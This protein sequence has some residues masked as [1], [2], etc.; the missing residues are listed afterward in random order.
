MLALGEPLGKFNASKNKSVKKDVVLEAWY[1]KKN[2]L[3]GSVAKDQKPVKASQVLNKFQADVLPGIIS[4]EPE[5]LAK[6]LVFLPQ[7]VEAILGG[8]KVLEL[9][10]TSLISNSEGEILYMAVANEIVGRAF[11]AKPIVIETAEQFEKM[12]SFHCWEGV[13]P[14]YAYP[15]VAH[16]VSQVQRLQPL[17]F[18]KLQGCRG[19]SLYRPLAGEEGAKLDEKKTAK[20]DTGSKTKTQKSDIK[21][22]RGAVL[23]SH[24][25]VQ[26]DVA[27]HLK[28]TK[29][30]VEKK[31]EFFK[32][33][34]TKVDLHIS[35][36]GLAHMNNLAF[37]RKSRLIAFLL[38]NLDKNVATVT[39]FWVPSWEEQAN[40]KE[41]STGGDDLSG[42]CNKFDV[43]LLGACLVCPGENPEPCV[44]K[45]IEQIYGPFPAW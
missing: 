34:A 44:L 16:P 7:W 9:R 10:K 4:E 26:V 1:S 45:E 29:E 22:L 43:C 32:R 31:L 24:Q 5:P 28:P 18:Q 12:K 25:V 6:I 37:P 19:R 21:V 17:K 2:V 8:K 42:F 38:G 20:Q 35:A 39:C 40:L 13:D 41:V 23:A 3:K 30:R 27:Q 15:F 33:K 36:G 14:P 11:F